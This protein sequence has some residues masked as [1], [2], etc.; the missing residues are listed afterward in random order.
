MKPDALLRLHCKEKLLTEALAILPRSCFVG[1]FCWDTE[2]KVI[3]AN[4][5]KAP[6][7]G[8]PPDRL[9]GLVVSCFSSLWVSQG[10]GVGPGSP[11]GGP[12]L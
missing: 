1:S 10:C 7:A 2:S 5:G 12:S 4:R 8:V 6:P 11:L 3:E 9:F